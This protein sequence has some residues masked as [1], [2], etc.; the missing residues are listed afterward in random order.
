MAM[1]EDGNPLTRSI[2]TE[3]WARITDL[4]GRALDYSANERAAFLAQLRDE[5]PAAATEVE[6]LLSAHDRGGEF[7]PD[8]PAPSSPLPD[9]AGRSVGA[10]RW[11]RLLG[12]GGMG[13]VYLAERSD[14]A[15]SKHVA[16]KLLSAAFLQSRD[17]FHREREF[18]A[19]LY[20]PNITRLIDAGATP[21]GLPYLVMEYVEGIPIDRYCADCDLSVD[22]RV[23]LLLQV[24][25]GVAHAHQNL[26]IHCDIKPENIL[27]TPNGTTKLLDFGVAKLLDPARGMTLYRPATPAYSS[28]EQ[29]HGDPVTTASDVYSIGMVGYVV[30]TGGRP[31]PWRSGRLDELV[32]AI[33]TAEPL[34]ASQV[35]GL[36][37]QRA[38]T[39]RGDLDNVLLKAIAKDPHRRY[40]SVQQLADDF[41]AYRSGFP[42]RARADTVVYRLRKTVTRHRFASAAAAL[43]VVSLLVAAGFSTWQARIANRRF[44][45][46]R[47]LAH[48]L[49]FDVNDALSPIPGTTAARK[50]VVETA[51][52]YLDR[53]AGDRSNA[54]PLR[55]EL[56]AAYIRIG[57]VQGGA[58][59][60]NLGDTSGAVASFRKALA[61]IGE[62]DTAPGPERLRIEAHIN[63]GLLASDPIRGT[64]A[65]DNA[66]DAARRL[67]SAHADDASSLRFVADAYHGK[68]TIAHLTNRVPD[69]V[70]MSVREVEVREQI[71]ALSPDSWQD[72]AGL[73]RAIAQHALALEQQNNFMDAAS[74]LRRARSILEAAI[75]RH[76]RNQILTRGL[77][78]VRSRI[79]SPLLALGRTD[80]AS[81]EVELAIGL[82]EPLVASDPNNVQYKADLAYGWLRLG[83]SRRAEGRLVEALDLHRKALAVRRERAARDAGFAFVPWE[84]TRSLNTVAELLL[85][86][87]PAKPEEAVMLFEEARN[88]GERALAAAPS[89]NQL[90]KQAANAD[91]GLA[92]ASLLGH[93]PAADARVFL[94]RSAKRWR[95][96]L[97]SS[98]GD[99]RDADRAVRVQQQLDSLTPPP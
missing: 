56:A 90:R 26:I 25:A 87:S 46:L 60:P 69:H 49:V 89:H 57:K 58:F 12:S 31:Y 51:L 64:P 77:A 92:R 95:E 78:E 93:R 19:R 97:A 62:S 48:A 33:I 63:I 70:A 79:A 18:L 28:P 22:E 80:E 38:R 45:Q 24:C 13:T 59:L 61:A 42:V 39:L 8:L 7:L 10:Y 17:R 91:E 81:R 47:T 74:D 37:P 82:L 3:A 6:S 32:Q 27:I 34:R 73:A 15:F 71:V 41:E 23:G 50:L 36:P 20:H 9:L 5:D 14:G 65:F 72:A 1:N 53:L 99:L 29:L 86:V 40:A 30:L 2:T 4:F 96:V 94:E 54:A 84:L 44:D 83:D 66:I 67:L 68:A 21:E 98:S 88:V 85:A 35:A 75:D 55:E 76:P 43:S 16:V 11:L 52:R